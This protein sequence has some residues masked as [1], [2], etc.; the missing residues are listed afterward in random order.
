[1]SKHQQLNYSRTV[2]APF[3]KRLWLCVLAFFLLLCTQSI[4]AQERSKVLMLQVQ[5]DPSGLY[6]DAQMN[7][8]LPPEVQEVLNKGIALHFIATATVYRKRW[9]WFDAVDAQRSRSVRLSFQPIL[10]H[11]RVS[12]GGLNQTF[13]TLPE[14]LSLLGS[15]SRWRIADAG[16]VRASGGQTLVF[17]FELDRSRLPQMFQL[18]IAGEQVWQIRLTQEVDLHIPQ[19]EVAQ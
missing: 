15:I 9:Y 7:L 5:S 10:Q 13:N 17:T 18:S 3:M 12:I 16:I 11:Y 4:Y 6:L 2:P 19:P 14:A 8:V 1:M